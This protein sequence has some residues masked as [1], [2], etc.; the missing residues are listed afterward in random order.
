MGL[1]HESYLGPLQQSAPAPDPGAAYATACAALTRRADEQ[2][3]GG[4]ASESSGLPEVN[5]DDYVRQLRACYYALQAH[6]QP[7]QHPAQ[8]KQQL[9]PA[10]QAMPATPA[11][12]R[13]RLGPG[14]SLRDGM[15]GSG[16]KG[17]GP[18]RLLSAPA[19]HEEARGSRDA[20]SGARRGAGLGMSF[21]KWWRMSLQAVRSPRSPGAD[22]R[23]CMHERY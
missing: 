18:L 16:A 20:A 1:A 23:G 3:A 2:A 17:R 6:A 14:G 19:A 7:P 22:G 4:A 9:E 12:L 5:M 11:S 10:L 15:G 13:S 21:M 8:D